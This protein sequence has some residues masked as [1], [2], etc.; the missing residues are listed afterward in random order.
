MDRM[1]TAMCV[2]ARRDQVPTLVQL[3]SLQGKMEIY[4]LFGRM[5]E[6][7]LW[8]VLGPTPKFIC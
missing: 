3:R 5:K 1:P 7:L 4:S 6:E 2:R 8:A